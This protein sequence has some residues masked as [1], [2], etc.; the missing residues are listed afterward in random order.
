MLT[1]CRKIADEIAL[2]APQDKKTIV[3]AFAGVGGNAIAFALSGHWSMIFAI[4]KDPT[5]LE[6]AKHNAKVYGV[7]KKIVWHQGDVFTILQDRMKPVRSNSVLF[8]SPPWGGP[9][10]KDTKV[11][12]LKTMR[13][14]NLQQLYRPL[15]NYTKEIALYLPRT[16]DLK[17]IAE[18]ADENEHFEVVHYAMMGASKV[19]APRPPISPCIKS[20]NDSRPYAFT[21]E[22]LL[23]LTE[24]PAG[25]L[26][27]SGQH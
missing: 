20:A 1:A 18:L 19:F 17:Q 21:V 24:T 25:D 10:Y 6:C 9:N 22:R 23:A 4:E 11:F 27:S 15:Q 7:S 2:Y 14:Y 3:D 16:S 26:N 12:D 13:P 5:T 8:A